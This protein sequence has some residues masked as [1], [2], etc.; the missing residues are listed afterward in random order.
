MNPRKAN[1]FFPEI[2]S[3]LKID[4]DTVEAIVEFYWKELKKEL[5][6]PSHL[7]IAVENFGTFEIRKK[8]V[9]YMINKYRN[10]ISRMKP[11]TY[12]KHTLMN[13]AVEKLARLEK[14]MELLQVQEQKKQQVREL[15]RNG[16]TV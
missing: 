8:Q 16:K 14:L 3:E 13:I 12:T 4:E 7:T 2:A 11:S 15:Q 6:E 10:L 9:E 1:T 5:T